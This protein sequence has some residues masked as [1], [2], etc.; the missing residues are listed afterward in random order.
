MNIVFA[1]FPE[2][3]SGLFVGD[4]Q[5]WL[6]GDF[7]ASL[8]M[9]F[10]AAGLLLVIGFVMLFAE[11]H[12]LAWSRDVSQRTSRFP[13]VKTGK[14]TMVGKIEGLSGNLGDIAWVD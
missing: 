12:S 13:E 8:I 1:Q 3:D 10:G 2:K 4:Y 7:R 9:L 5:R 6:A 11:R 14:A